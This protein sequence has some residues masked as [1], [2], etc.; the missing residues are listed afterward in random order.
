MRPVR[1]AA[2]A[3]IATV[4]LLLAGCSSDEPAASDSAGA[5]ESPSASSDASEA[6][7]AV[8][9]F[10]EVEGYTLVELP[11]AAR[12]AF[13]AATQNAPQLEDFD[14]RMIE[15]DGQ[16]VGM[17]MRVGLD[18]D[19]SDLGDFE[20]QFLPGFASGIAGADVKP[21]FEEI[22]GI[23]VVKIETPGGSGT[24][25]AWIESSVATILV[26]NSAEDAAAYAQGATS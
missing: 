26:F 9:D 8:G 25:Y 20:K 15:K 16:Q 6:P 22:N 24:A 3:L 1:V 10:A 7:A 2:V 17:V 23:K 21:D 5:S 13:A 18:V 12:Q 19:Q 4:G 11:D 14:G